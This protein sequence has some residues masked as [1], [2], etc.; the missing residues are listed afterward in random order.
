MFRDA[1]LVDKE[2]MEHDT[3]ENHEGSWMAALI[4]GARTTMKKMPKRRLQPPNHVRAPS[5]HQEKKT[6]EWKMQSWTEQGEQEGEERNAMS[7]PMG[8][9]TM[10]Q[11]APRAMRSMKDRFRAQ[12]I[13]LGRCRAQIIF[14][15]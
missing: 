1:K 10:V 15:G 9:K 11:H 5:E 12:I 6:P 13:G 3:A 8:K 7:E 4:R 2:L 14:F